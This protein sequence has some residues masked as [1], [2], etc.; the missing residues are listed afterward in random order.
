M[1][2]LELLPQS[3]QKAELRSRWYNP[4]EAPKGVVD[5]RADD[6][7]L[8]LVPGDEV[9]EIFTF[10]VLSSQRSRSIMTGS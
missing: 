4:S 1:I 7:L 10:V 2:I 3:E 9:F 6:F 5:Y 8:L